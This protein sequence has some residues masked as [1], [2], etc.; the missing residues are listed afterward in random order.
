[1]P[2]YHNLIITIIY[3]I[4]NYLQTYHITFLNSY[5]F[6]LIE[7]F[8]FRS[9][10]LWTL[11][12]SNLNLKGK[13]LCDNEL[14]LLLLVN[15][16]IAARSLATAGA[17][18]LGVLQP[19][20]PTR[21]THCSQCQCGSGTANRRLKLSS[22]SVLCLWWSWFSTT[23]HHHGGAQL[24]LAR[25]TPLIALFFCLIYIYSRFKYSRCVTGLN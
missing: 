25:C 10:A 12:R 24:S 11:E 22:S 8:K 23:R 17:G 1:M 5:V 16:F 6:K 21:P 15:T 19:S 3:K 9:W 4:Q 2:F 14:G 20:A 18:H 7:S 13:F